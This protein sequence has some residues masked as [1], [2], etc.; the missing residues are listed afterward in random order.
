LRPTGAQDELGQPRLCI[1]VDSSILES[2]GGEAQRFGEGLLPGHHL[3]GQT[4]G[5]G[6]EREAVMGMAEG[7]PQAPVPLTSADHGNHVGVIASMATLELT[8]RTK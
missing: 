6:S 1:L 3:G 8:P 5:D 4:P 7:E 2:A